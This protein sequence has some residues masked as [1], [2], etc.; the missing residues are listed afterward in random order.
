MLPNQLEIEYNICLDQENYDVYFVLITSI[1]TH[2]KSAMHVALHFNILLIGNIN[3]ALPS[4]WHKYQY[5]NL[6][7]FWASLLG[8]KGVEMNKSISISQSL[9]QSSTSL[10]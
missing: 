7:H 10:K 3:N 5:V 1:N 8:I 9:L 4:A 2:I 6:K